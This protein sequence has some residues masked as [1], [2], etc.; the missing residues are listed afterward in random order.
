MKQIFSL[1]SLA[2]LTAL[3]LTSP[4]AVNAAEG[5]AT[6]FAA[7]S[8]Q[9]K[10]NGKYMLLDFTGSD[11]CGWCIKLDREVFA[12]D[13]FK[14]FAKTD[15]VPVML[16][17]PRRKKLAPELAQQ[18]NALRVKYGVRGYP[19]I[20]VLSPDGDLVQK[21]GYRRGGPEAYVT[22][23]QQIITAHK[24]KATGAPA[25]APTTAAVP[26]AVPAATKVVAAP[27]SPTVAPPSPTAAPAPA[28]TIV[29]PP[30]AV[31]TKPTVTLPFVEAGEGESALE[32][33]RAKAKAEDKML[34]VEFGWDKCGN[35]RNFRNLL[36]GSKV[37]VPE[38]E[39]V[40]VNV[41]PREGTDR[42]KFTEYFGIKQGVYPRI[43]IASPDGEVL[44]SRF[45]YGQAKQYNDLID[46]ARQEFASLTPI[47][48]TPDAF[49]KPAHP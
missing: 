25:A 8:K 20:L 6:D 47:T 5:W 3:L 18:N 12:K 48:Y 33:A 9:A 17:F 34:F 32:L 44:G 26:A 19:T 22:H 13:E 30:A 14:A 10:D 43:V 1:L 37:L 41:H 7:A 49:F 21:T 42:N 29:S 40:M 38:K 24:A 27:P 4:N 28:A 11:W 31:T 39:F 46:T 23:L 15:L 35:C 36:T 16:D 2:T 45:G